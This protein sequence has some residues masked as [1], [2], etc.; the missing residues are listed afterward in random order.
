MEQLLEPIR[1]S[2][3]QDIYGVSLSSIALSFAILFA[4]LVLGRILLVILFNRLHAL[5]KRTD[6][7]WDDAVIEAIR[8]PLRW[9]VLSYGIWLA[10]YIPAASV[11]APNLFAALQRIG[12]VIFLFFLAWLTYRLIDVVDAILHSRA[13][14]PDD[15]VDMG[16]VPLFV[17]SL[18]ILVVIVFGLVLAQNLGYS[19]AG[20]IASL[21]I[22]GAALALAS[23]DTIA[24]MFGSIMILLDKPFKV[25]DWISG[26]GFEGIV[27]R[28][29]FRSTRIRTF[30]KTVENIPNNHLANVTVENM[31]RRKDPGLGVRRIK[32]TVGVTYS[33]TADQME[34]A[35]EAIRQILKEDE[36]VDQRMTTLVNFTDFGDSSL[37][38]FIYYFSNSANWQ[39]YLDVRQRVNLKIMRKLEEMGLE[40]AFPTRSLHIESVP[41][42]LG[43]GAPAA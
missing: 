39:Y 5:A 26:D 16:I 19:I 33:T 23:Q 21:G 14:D 30:A 36:G 18:R 29:G 28:I 22:G 15:W 6:F 10:I 9:L 2:L 31:D 37:D 24:N 35:V 38:I 8:K 34:K 25:G 4:S 40:I 32:M 17:S 3:S 13:K 11:D 12:Q 27:E 41:R 20:L 1:G 7:P 43:G 42:E